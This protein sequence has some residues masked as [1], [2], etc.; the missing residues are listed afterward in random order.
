METKKRTY[1]DLINQT[2]ALF[3]HEF[4]LVANMKN[5]V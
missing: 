1:S 4:D 5:I 3:Q 2:K